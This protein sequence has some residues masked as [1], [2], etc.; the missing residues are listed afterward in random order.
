MKTIKIS[1]LLFYLLS[2]ANLHAQITTKVNC[3]ANSMNVEIA[4]S[5]PQ[6]NDYSKGKFTVR[7]Y[8]EFT[9]PS[10]Q[11][12]YKLPLYELIFAIP[13]N[14]KPL[15]KVIDSKSSVI[16]NIILEIQPSLQKK[17]DS[18]LVM[19]NISINNVVYKNR[20]DIIEFGEYF[21]FRDF[22]CVSVKVNSHIFDPQENQLTIF[23]SIRF[24]LDFPSNSFI[25]TPS[26]LR[27]IS[28]FDA[29]LKTIFAN[30]EIAE[31]FRTKTN[32]NLPDT[33]GN[34]MNY[35]NTYLKIGVAEDGIFRITKVDLENM[36]INASGI[37]PATFALF[38]S[39]TEQQIY[40][41]GEADK[42]FDDGDFI[43]FFGCR[44]YTGSHR[45][46][47]LDNQDYNEFLNRY[48]DTTFYFLTWGSNRGKRS[49]ISNIFNSS[50]TDTLDYYTFLFHYEKNTMLQ[51]INNDEIANQT[52]SWLKNKTWYDRWIFTSP[53]NVTYSAT[54]RFPNKPAKVFFKLVS[55]ASNLSSNAHN[56]VLKFND[57]KV[58]TQTIDRFKQVL[59]TGNINSNQIVIGNNKITVHNYANGSSPNMIGVDWYELEYPRELK[60][61]NGFNYFKIGDESV[62]L[63]E[64]VIKI[65]NVPSSEVYIYQVKPALKKI[66]NFSLVNQILTFTDTV[67]Y[68]YEYVV[69]TQS[70]FKTPH[71]YYQKRFVNLRN[72][73]RQADYISITSQLFRNEVINYNSN[74]ATKYNLVTASF[75]VGDIFDEFGFGYPTPY[76]IRLFLNKC[77][78]NWQ[79]PKPSYLTLIGDASYDYKDYFFQNVGIKLSTNF[80]PAFGV[81]V[82]DNWYAIWDE[83][84]PPLPQLKVGRLPV[85]SVSQL[86]YYIS[87]INNNFEG[88]YDEWNKRYL[89]FSGGLGG[90]NEYNLLKSVN[91]TIITRF[92]QPRPL[93]GKFHHF[94]KTSNPPSDFGPYTPEEIDNAIDDGSVFISYIGHSG[95]STWDNSIINSAQL[96]NSNNKNPLITDFGCSTNKYGEPDIVCFGEKFV[97]STEGQALGYIGNSSLGFFSTS[98]TVSTYFYEKII[99]DLQHEIGSAHLQAKTQMFNNLGSS[100]SYKVFALTN[101]LVGDPAVRIKIPSKPNLKISSSNFFF[102][103]EFVNE[104]MDSVKI[105]IVVNNYGSS[106]NNEYVLSCVHLFS[107]A[108]IQ[109]TTFIRVLPLYQDTISVWLKIKNTPGEHSLVVNLDPGNLIDELNEGDNSATYNFNVYSVALRDLLTSKFENPAI[110]NLLLLNPTSFPDSSF[111]IKLDISDKSDF[112]TFNSISFP[113][114]T[115]YSKLN[116]NGMTADKRYWFR[117]KINEG[118]QQYSE[119]KS[120]FNKSGKKYFLCDDYSF[121]MQNRSFLK[122]ENNQLLVGEDTVTIS[123]LSAGW[124]AGGTCG[125]SRNGINEL[126][127]SFFAGMGIVV[128]NPNTLDVEYSESYS[129][130]DNA[131]N[132]QAL[133]DYL[134]S[135][136]VGKLVVM[137]V[138]DDGQH[139]LSTALKDAIKTLGSTKIDSL[140]FRSSWAIIGYKGSAP[141]DCIEAYRAPY[142]GQVYLDTT[143]VLSRD[144]GKLITNRIGP[145][146]KYSQL[147]VSQNI[148]AGTQIK[149]RPY[150]IRSN[151]V[152]DTLGYLTIS[153]TNADLSTIDSKVY[154]YLQLESELITSEEGTSPILSSIGI[155][156]TGLPELGINYQVVSVDADSVMQGN[157][158]NLN[159]R[160]YNAGEPE[161]ANVRVKLGLIKSDNS[162]R[163]LLDSMVA[164]IPTE[165]FHEFNYQYVT[166]T[167]DGIGNLAFEITIDPVNEIQEYY[168]DN[169]YFS[170]EFY[171]NPDTNVTSV[172]NSTV[173]V[174]YDGAEI[175]DGDYINPIP[176]IIAELNYPVWFPFSDTSAVQFYLDGNKI[177][178]DVLS[179]TNYDTVNRNINYVL[180]P[181]LQPG[182]HEL[183]IFGEN[184]FG[185]LESQPGYSRSFVVSSEAQLM[186]VYNYPNPF[187]DNTYF[188]FILTQVPDDILIKIYSVA[189]RL[190]KEIKG[191]AVELGITNPG[192][193]KILWNGRDEDGDL[194]ANG[195]YLY[196]VIINKDSKSVSTVQK[197]VI[198]R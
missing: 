110:S 128:F 9:D 127:N 45:V 66:A 176:K 198:M 185:N 28:A 148:P 38:E 143:F 101:V 52:S 6:N 175:L 51:L 13:A 21:W 14:S 134:N 24:E 74:I 157:P 34:W 85:L 25:E 78:E 48:T 156:Y 54:D 50:L 123:V 105:N 153:G 33:T 115:F 93:A 32:F 173:K 30:S 106:P 3:S 77:Y 98:T 197:L 177:Y 171:V 94:Y 35:N 117:Y 189:G 31:Q 126:L 194:I 167:N 141:G 18:T 154:P 174:F 195:T 121:N 164:A 145:A 70:N 10:H 60:L 196:K 188:T 190:L 90:D 40:V 71:F 84:A 42:I 27:K 96:M 152:V 55:A 113:S 133:A 92:I 161:A 150:G 165:Q 1:F 61:N 180:T 159:F 65:G 158:I 138:S 97:L 144:R 2:L 87:K 57:V 102:D 58:D 184:V 160:A 166:N 39:G 67:G 86:S 62:N 23:N 26:Q 125:I 179:E 36:G 142:A 114:D 83:N 111:N 131:P 163:T 64:R 68:G 81:P 76:A 192:H 170:K 129:L 46:I 11:G 193:T 140:V 183:R 20:R 69:F 5:D 41:Q 100:G 178:R 37:D 169:N 22:Y 155:D 4:I 56:V 73:N 91:D 12:E 132:A 119:T 147:T 122:S 75:M 146:T 63:M 136:P 187:S 44:N 118:S 116:L 168:E 112:S 186:S 43:E 15:L 47:N 109:D 151:G 79:S 99:S 17:N 19:E 182:I 181:N 139:R 53:S 172:N 137:G 59:L 103:S 191:T 162:K 89:F 130:F 88:D 108:S 80:I 95:T 29:E 104:S 8:L 124:Y 49:L 82:S 135:I 149:Y 107:G 16:N 120:F 72:Y 7:D